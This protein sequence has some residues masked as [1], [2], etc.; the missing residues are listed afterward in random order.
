MITDGAGSSSFIVSLF[1]TSKC[2]GIIVSVDFMNHPKI[3]ELSHLS[4]QD[5]ERNKSLKHN[6][7]YLPLLFVNKFISKWTFPYFAPTYQI[8]IYEKIGTP[9]IY[10]HYPFYW[11]DRRLMCYPTNDVHIGTLFYILLSRK[12]WYKS[13]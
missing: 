10:V 4:Y 3:V 13:R 7:W 5:I 6:L 12:K 11:E 9:L 2:D 1:S 8:V